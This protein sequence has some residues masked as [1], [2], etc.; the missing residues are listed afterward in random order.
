MSA[1]I[2]YIDR[3]DVRE[4]KLSELKAAIKE[5]ADFVESHVPRS[6][7]Y[8]VYLNEDESRMTVV[9][10]HPDSASL[11]FHIEVAGPAFRKFKDLI[12]LST[13][14]IYGEPSEQLRLRLLEKARMLGSGT[15]TVHNRRAGFSRLQV[16]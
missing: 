11:E 1:P 13:M 15:V 8:S 2:V 9:Q 10:V 12:R 4:G 6:M 5:L 7:A 14:D 3:S 16:S